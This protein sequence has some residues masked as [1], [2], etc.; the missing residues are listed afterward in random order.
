[1]I[2][3]TPKISI[4]KKEVKQSFIHASG[5]GGQNI[6]KVA[7][8]VQLRFD[9]FNTP[10][11]PDDVKERLVHIA[12]KRITGDGILII[13][14][15]RFRKQESNRRDAINRLVNL[16]RKAVEK[17]KQ[18]YKTKSTK[19]SVFRRLDSKHQRSEI[20]KLRKPVSQVDD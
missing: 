1:M 4:K 17:P 14:A 2:F 5:P 6:N 18:R 3:V 20:K 10:S 16:I 9:V 12:G 7:T 11:L 13:I 19:E 15:K 8:A